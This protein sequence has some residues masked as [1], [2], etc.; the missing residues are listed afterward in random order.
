MRQMGKEQA[1]NMLDYTHLQPQQAYVPRAMA[2]LAKLLDCLVQVS[3]PAEIKYSAL[4]IAFATAMNKFGS[5]ILAAH[6]QCEKDMLAGEGADSLTVLL[7]HWRRVTSSETSFQK[8][9]HKLDESQASIMAG[10]R[11]RM[12]DPSKT[13]KAKRRFLN[14]EDSE[15]TMASDG[16][17]AMLATQSDSEGGGSEAES[18]AAQS[19][20]GSSCPGLQKSPSPVL[21]AI[22]EQQ[23]ENKNEK[24]FCKE[25]PCKRTKG[26]K[27]PCKGHKGNLLKKKQ[28]QRARDLQKMV[29][30]VGQM[31]ST[32][33]L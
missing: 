1:F 10:L 23:L 15:V 29:P 9:Q 31:L 33:H 22:G 8:F 25:G 19:V 18:S 13:T 28:L 20:A 6:F 24:T 5:D 21:R 11:K 27:Q 17:S 26:G 3:P 2:K 14:N 4:K 30:G 7:K 12:A 32:C 16:F